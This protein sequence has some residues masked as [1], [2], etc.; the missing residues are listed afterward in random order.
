[1]KGDTM[2]DLTAKCSVLQTEVTVINPLIKKRNIAN[3]LSRDD[4]VMLIVLNKANGRIS[5]KDTHITKKTFK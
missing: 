4:I 2:G 1:M 3:Q 5:Y